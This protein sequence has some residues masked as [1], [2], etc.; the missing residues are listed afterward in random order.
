VAE[1][2]GLIV[3]GGKGTRLRPMEFVVSRDEGRQPRAHRFM[4]G[5]NSDL[6]IL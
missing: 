5:D 2:K 4:V 3:S 6:A 1:L